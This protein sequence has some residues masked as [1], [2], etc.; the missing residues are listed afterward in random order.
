MLI[1]AQLLTIVRRL[2]TSSYRVRA[3]MNHGRMTTIGL[4]ALHAGAGGVPVLGSAMERSD[5][6]PL[7]KRPRFQDLTLQVGRKRSF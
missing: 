2:R 6:E 7:S 3:R 1:P 5:Q 4:P